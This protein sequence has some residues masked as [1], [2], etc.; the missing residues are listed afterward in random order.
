MSA[1]EWD[2]ISRQ[3]EQCYL[4]DRWP[5]RQ[6]LQRLRRRS[7]G[8]EALAESLAE[9]QRR[10]A[11]SQARV[12]RRRAGVPNISYPPNLPVSERLEDIRAAIEGHQVV[13]LAGATGSGKTT[14][15]PKLC[16]QMGRGVSGMIA[17][18]QPRRL[19]ART[20]A[21]RI[22]DELGTR[23]GE[24]VAYQVRFQDVSSDDSYIKLMTDG[25]L[26]AAIQQDRYLNQY[27]TI[28]ID[29]AHERSLNIDFLLGYLKTLLPKRPDLKIIITSATIDLERFSA[30]FDNAPVIEVSGRTFPVEYRY[31]PLEE[32]SAE[33]DLGVGIEST[34][35]EL[36]AEGAHQRGDTLVFLSGE[37]EIRETAR[38]LRNA[39]LPG[40]DILPLYARL[41]AGEQQRIFDTSKRR[42]WRVVLATNV[43]ETSLTV[44]GIHYVI[45]AGTA[46]ISRYSV[47]SKVQRLPIEPISQASANQRS[48]R[49]GRL[50]PGI[51]YRLYS[52]D[53]FE[54]R[55]AFT[56]PEIQRTNLAAVILQMLQLGLGDIRKF[57]FV[58]PPDS[59]FVRDG[60]ALLQELGAVE[61]EKLTPLGRQLGKF[62]VD[63]RIGRLLLAAAEKGCLNEMLI[64]ASALSIQDPRERPADKQQAADEKHRRF[65][66]EQSDF[67]A[68]VSLWEYAEEQRQA[69]SANQWQKLCKREF[70]SWMRMREWR[71][72][73]HQLRLM[74]RQ[75][76][77][78][79]NTE[80]ADYASVHQ[81]LLPGFLGQIANR[82]EAREY[83][84]ARNRSLRIFPGSSLRKKTP[85]WIVAAELAE[86]SQ[87]FAR[88][89]AAIE[90]EWLFGINDSLLKRHYHEPRWQAR[91]GRVMAYEQTLLYG[92]C[93]RDRHRV[94]YG[95]ID[96]VVSREILIREALVE[97]R[98]RGKAAF[99]AHNRRLI[100][101]VAE[102]EDKARRRD[103][104]VSDEELFRY[105]DERIPAGITTAKQ[106][107]SWLKKSA[108]R[109]LLKMSRGDVMRQL[110][111]V[112]G[113]QFPDTM[114]AGGIQL[115]LEYRF[116]PG[117]PEDGVSVRLPLKYL[118]SIP[119]GRFHWLVPGLLREKCIALVKAL[120]KAQR[121]QLVPVPDYVDRALSRM[122]PSDEPLLPALAAR[123]SQLSDVAIDLSAWAEAEIDD[124]YRANIKV[125]D[126]T[127]K[128]LEQGRDM[129]RLREVLA[130]AV[131]RSIAEESADQFDRQ[132]LHEWTIPELPVEHQFKQAGATLTA[133]PC[134]RD[135]GDGVELGLAETLDE[136]TALSERGVLRLLLLRLPQ[137][138]KTLRGNLF[139]DNAIQLQFA[140][141]GQNKARWLE[142]CLLVAARSVFLTEGTRLPRTEDEFDKIWQAGRANFHDQAQAYGELLKRILAHFSS[143]KRRLK[144][145]NSLSWIHSINDIQHQLAGLFQEDFIC[146]VEGDILAEYPRYLAA[147]EE[148]LDKLDGHYQRDRQCTLVV[149]PLQQQC[150]ALLERSPE[151]WQKS[152]LL[153]EYR[154][155]LEE[156]RV[157]LFAQRLGTRQSVSEKRLKQLWKELQQDVTFS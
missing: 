101:E 18:T 82:A 129:R 111:S 107:E 35:R 41:S 151:L 119:D 156:L 2:T 66:H 104:L 6:H 16:L 73:H 3:I 43:A 65:W 138:V 13:V 93:I 132:V 112:D 57:P 19:A 124:Y 55:P 133:Y 147:I 38:H 145:L 58:D 136:A 53:D 8:D 45:D 85:P 44:P 60:Y 17:H 131:Q 100:A 30:H 74:A 128:V 84:G 7:E 56:E 20:V 23:V 140:A 115:A 123:L 142:N 134:L 33:Q 50:A 37:R 71:E 70:L 117:H 64:I 61:N 83:L 103:M 126:E 28:I 14:Q 113:A 127:G 120:P 80:P 40:A 87:L 42:G 67:M 141:T 59:R 130:D 153:R 24:A 34:L 25:I 4:P 51:A 68:F 114:T 77:L 148:R 90:P 94:H 12:E 78:K 89:V 52:E 76:K 96:P 152:P 157:S 105:Y 102:M 31:R 47:R 149:E 26:L 106:L 46:R 143:I 95:P 137:Q 11:Q 5:L 49:C 154:W 69:L 27:D 72:V 122:R 98:Y 15:I 125:L 92:L 88:C 86:T 81:A 39:E 99:F 139:R 108:D 63:P 110:E 91:T 21:E 22:A 155:L 144:K 97:G 1:V 75:M 79:V 146:R 135:L 10:M 32:L 109:D 150:G 29:E 36:M 62:P 9:L 118:H 48:G 116:E 121:K 54:R